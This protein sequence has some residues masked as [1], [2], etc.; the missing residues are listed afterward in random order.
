MSSYAGPSA[1]VKYL[2]IVHREF[3][4]GTFAWWWPLTLH[5]HGTNHKYLLELCQPPKLAKDF[6]PTCSTH[7]WQVDGGPIVCVASWHVNYKRSWQASRLGKPLPLLLSLVLSLHFMCGRGAILCRSGKCSS[8][9]ETQLGQ[10]RVAG[11]GWYVGESSF[12]NVV[13]AHKDVLEVHL[14]QDDLGLKS[15]KSLRLPRP[16]L[17]WN[18]CS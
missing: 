17:T 11:K 6:S 4:T 15:G 8:S 16:L 7:K 12:A 18:C 9:T 10:S 3:M 2:D 1:L 5:Y 13:S 14:G